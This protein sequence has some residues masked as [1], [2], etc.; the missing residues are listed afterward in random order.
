MENIHIKINEYSN[1]FQSICKFK[2]CYRKFFLVFLPE[3]DLFLRSSLNDK[4]TDTCVIF[5]FIIIDLNLKQ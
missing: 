2:N 5:R 4:Q 1:Q 3:E